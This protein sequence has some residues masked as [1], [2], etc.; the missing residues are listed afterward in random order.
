[1]N[2]GTEG[3]NTPSEGEGTEDNNT[4][5]TS[6]PDD[7]D[8]PSDEDSENKDKPNE[9]DGDD[10]SGKEDKPSTG[11]DLDKE[12]KPGND[13]DKTNADDSLNNESDSNN[14]DTSYTEE[15]SDSSEVSENNG[16]S[17]NA[18]ASNKSESAESI[19]ITALESGYTLNQINLADKHI[20]RASLLN[21]YN[22][23]RMYLAAIMQPDFG[24]MIDM[25]QIPIIQKDIEVSYSISAFAELSPEFNTVMLKADKA[26]QLGFNTI[27]NFNVGEAYIGKKAYVYMLN[28]TSTGY[29]FIATTYVDS[30]GNVAFISD[31]ATDYIILV[32]K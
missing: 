31:K 25:T 28:D 17:S 32:E 2:E 5:N 26:S 3:N 10:D 30:I 27:F 24:L 20:L 1:L 7:K 4:P 19:L 16:E 8:I 18:S 21:K 29:D 15:N 11:D 23:Q 14:Q 9:D 22:G 6:K 13:E 12:D